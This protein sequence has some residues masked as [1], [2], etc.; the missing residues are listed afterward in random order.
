MSEVIK[1][2][3]KTLDRAEK[4][5]K[6]VNEFLEEV[7]AKLF[8]ITV[9]IVTDEAAYYKAEIETIVQEEAAEYRKVYKID[10]GNMKPREYEKFV[11]K[12]ID[13]LDMVKN[14]RKQSNMVKNKDSLK[15]AREDLIESQPV[16]NMA[17]GAYSDYW[18]PVSPKVISG[19]IPPPPYWPTNESMSGGKY[20]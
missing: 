12:M 14:D 4:Q 15:K 6:L 9:D 5:V 10:V 3:E 18:I 8:N 2:M 13:K 16:T 1:R 7:D 17:I 11:A 19:H 20:I